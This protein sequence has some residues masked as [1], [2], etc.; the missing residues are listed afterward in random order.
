MLWSEAAVQDGGRRK[1]VRAAFAR[2]PETRV[3]VL[4]ALNDCAF[5]ILDKE[6]QERRA[7]P[8]GMP[9]SAAA[10]SER[11]RRLGHLREG[12]LLWGDLVA[13][14]CH[15]EGGGD[16]WGAGAA[17]FNDHCRPSL[18]LRALLSSTQ[19]QG[20]SGSC[21]ERIAPAA[22]ALVR[23]RPRQRSGCWGRCGSAGLR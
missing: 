12:V 20:L 1:A 19:M 22:C 17:A 18:A 4:R 5:M 14:I 3:L 16:E 23:H 15:G 9:R 10:D 8:A 11:A 13:R 21:L 7:L 2:M 6:Q